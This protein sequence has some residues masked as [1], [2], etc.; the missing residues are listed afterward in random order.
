MTAEQQRQIAAKKKEDKKK[1]VIYEKQEAK[2]ITVAA[3]NKKSARFAHILEQA[4]AC[5]PGKGMSKKPCP[6]CGFYYKKVS[7]PD[8]DSNWHYVA[9]NDCKYC[10][11]A[12]PD[13]RRQPLRDSWRAKEDKKNS[14]KREKRKRL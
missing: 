6:V 3:R 10:P 5:Q 9:Y 11:F 8:T 2:R 1:K 4:E 7:N 13:T 12:D 14:A